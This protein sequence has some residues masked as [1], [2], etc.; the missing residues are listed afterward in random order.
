MQAAHITVGEAVRQTG[1]C[2]RVV[3]KACSGKPVSPQT[4]RLLG[5]VLKLEERL[6]VRRRR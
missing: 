1:L 2:K 6:M 3:L 4:A 5:S